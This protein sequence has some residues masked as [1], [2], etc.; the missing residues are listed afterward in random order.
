M[1]ELSG[2]VAVVTGAA[3]GIGKALAE[4]V[5]AA[6]MSV[7]LADVEAAA[8]AA[9]VRALQD[10][11]A[12]VAAQVTDVTQEAS[13]QALAD[14]AFSTFGKV[15]V[16]CNN[17]GVLHRN[18][19]T[20]EHTGADWRWVLDVNV[21]GVV[22]GIRAFVPRMIADGEPGHIVN[23]A[24]M[25]G[26][27]TGGPGT[28]PYDA[29]KHAVLS[30]TESLYKDLVLRASNLSASVLCPGAVDTNIFSA[31]RNR[32]PQYGDAAAT[33]GEPAA[34]R[35]TAASAS[36]QMGGPLEPASVAA[37]VED[38]IRANR[39]YVLAT[40]PIVFEWVRMGHTRMWDGRNPA[41]PRRSRR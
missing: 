24:S 8:L 20:W 4:R 7:V 28:A 37:A 6:G 38:A 32:A 36:A 30:I 27:A 35:V 41:V 23:T 14:F 18:K 33:A 29:S 2:R 5:V 15:H 13:V 12:S 1:D 9:T 11:G 16:L 25:A 34:S 19:A 22:H 10:A 26:L 39:F 40:Q 31:E 17:A 3:S 21:W